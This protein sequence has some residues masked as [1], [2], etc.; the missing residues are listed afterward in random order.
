[1]RLLIFLSLVM[2]SC[3]TRQNLNSEYGLSLKYNNGNTSNRTVVVFL[4][5][6]LSSKQLQSELNK[7]KLPNIEKFY[8]NGKKMSYAHTGFPSVTFPSITSLL[9]GS[10]VSSH[11]VYSNTLIQK[12][13]RVFFEKPTYYPELN[14]LIA[15]KTIFSEFQ[16][17]GLKTVSISYPYFSDVSAHIGKSDSK[18]A[19]SIYEKNY[20]YVDAKQL[21]AL[22][23]LLTQNKTQD[24]PDFIFVHLIGVDFTNHDAGAESVLSQSYLRFLD[25]E[26][27]PIF[28]LLQREKKRNVLSILTA[29]HGQQTISK[30]FDLERALSRDDKNIT[31]LNEGRYASLFA[32]ADWPEAKMQKILQ[33]YLLAPGIETIV[34]KGENKFMIHSKNFV[35][36]VF[37]SKDTPCKFN[38]KSFSLDQNKWYCPEAVTTQIDNLFYPYF[39]PNLVYYFQISTPPQVMFIPKSNWSFSSKYIGQHGGPTKDEVMTPLLLHN[40]SFTGSGQVPAIWDVLSFL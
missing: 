13:E 40:I 32:S 6:G 20:K 36:T 11:G 21:E 15:G 34:T 39:I 23:I 27:G 30:V 26:L 38:S 7:R 14:Q 22:R 2:V 25:K 9:T 29:D 19:L 1:M 24:W 31:V 8:L 4:I 28:D 33:K 10:P 35:S 3:S 18:S 37:L 16:K 17:K 12:G 5:D